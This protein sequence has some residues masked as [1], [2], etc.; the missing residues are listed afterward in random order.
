MCLVK[1]DSKFHDEVAKTLLKKLE[2]LALNGCKKINEHPIPYDDEYEIYFYIYL[3]KFIKEWGE[4]I[5]S[6]EGVLSPFTGAL[7]NLKDANVDFN[8]DMQSYANV[9]D[10][11]ASLDRQKDSRSIEAQAQ[12]VFGFIKQIDSNMW[13]DK[14]VASQVYK[15][16]DGLYRR[17]EKELQKSDQ[18]PNMDL[19]N[20]LDLSMK[21]SSLK[22]L[23]P[24]AVKGHRASALKI[25]QFNNTGEKGNFT[26]Y[27]M[28]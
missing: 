26:F 12:D 13:T 16:V 5:S 2:T 24:K 22:E 17:V 28:L 4:R 3:A 7:K 19:T 6:S 18:D 15:Q 25:A 11:R 21:L 14:D 27:E 10:E 20:L 8:V 23:I 9:A 1:S